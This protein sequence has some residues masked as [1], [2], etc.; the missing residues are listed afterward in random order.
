MN[1]YSFYALKNT[2]IEKTLPRL[3]EKIYNAGL[4]VHVLCQNDD[5]LKALDASI[6]TF[7]SNAFVP[8]G[9][10]Y[11]PQDTYAEHPIFLSLD[12]NIVNAASVF[13]SLQPLPLQ[14]FQKIIYFFDLYQDGAQLFEKHYQSLLLQNATYWQQTQAGG[15]EKRT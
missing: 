3:L 11:D 5:Q 15:W 12:Q 8:H 10:I 6:W 2:T 13:L 7:S 14:G 9:S 1:E 4:K